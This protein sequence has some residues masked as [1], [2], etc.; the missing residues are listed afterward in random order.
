VEDGALFVVLV[1]VVVIDLFIFGSITRATTTTITTNADS[2][3]G[4]ALAFFHR[5]FYLLSSILYPRRKWKIE[6]CRV[7]RGGGVMRDA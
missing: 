2:A 1:V 4:R 7:S 3:P 6:G 5:L